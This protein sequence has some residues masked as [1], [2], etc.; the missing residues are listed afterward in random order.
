MSQ[1][2]V[3]KYLH[4][5]IEA[6]EAIQDVTRGRTLDNYRNDRHLRSSVEREF[7]TIGEA[8]R[9]A[10]DADE[11][12]EP[13]I[14]EVRRIIG[15]RHQLV[16]RYDVV[17]DATVWQ[18]I[19]DDLPVRRPLQ[20]GLP[21]HAETEQ[22]GRCA[23]AKP[24]PRGFPPLPNSIRRSSKSGR[25]IPFIAAAWLTFISASVWPPSATAAGATATLTCR[26]R[27]VESMPR[28]NLVFSRGTWRRA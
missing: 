28:S 24:A 14:H 23:A 1:R 11:S 7:I 15:F 4:D 12:L 13:Q 22:R 6:G 8:L 20:N 18:I 3:R 26:W 5:V 10:I 27:L 21:L 16:H 17:D 25:T 19:Q 9:Q 2:D